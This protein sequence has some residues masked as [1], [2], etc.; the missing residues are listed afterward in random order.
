MKNRRFA[1]TLLYLTW[2][3]LRCDRGRFVEAFARRCLV[4]EQLKWLDMITSIIIH[5]STIVGNAF[6]TTDFE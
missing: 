6:K 3:L 4:K 5:A 2:S 1:N